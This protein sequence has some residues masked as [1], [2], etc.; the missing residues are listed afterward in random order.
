[1]RRGAA[2]GVPPAAARVEVHVLIRRGVDPLEGP[3]HRNRSHVR[4]RSSGGRTAFKLEGDGDRRGGRHTPSHRRAVGESEPLAAPGL[5][6]TW[7]EEG[8]SPSVGR[9]VLIDVDPVD[10]D[11]EV[12]DGVRFSPVEP[13][14]RVLAVADLKVGRQRPG[15]VVGLDCARVQPLGLARADGTD[16]RGDVGGGLDR[17]GDQALAHT[18]HRCWCADGHEGDGPGGSDD[19]ATR[20]MCGLTAWKGRKHWGTPFWTSPMEG[21]RRR[22]G[23]PG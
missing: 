20:G 5:P 22:C 4:P 11:L 21:A 9:A 19:H 6:K 3:V 18:S 13:R 23:S 10:L 14:V 1:M 12:A 17:P 16:R 15:S 2:F 8:G 7:Q